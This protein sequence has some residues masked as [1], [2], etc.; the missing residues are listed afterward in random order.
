MAAAHI[1]THTGVIIPDSELSK[2]FTASQ[3]LKEY[4]VLELTK[5]PD[6]A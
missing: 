1:D 3:K 2:A 6:G 4:L 5:N